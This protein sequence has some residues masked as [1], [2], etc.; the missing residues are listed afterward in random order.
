MCD[1]YLTFRPYARFPPPQV[2]IHLILYRIDSVQLYTL[3]WAASV[4]ALFFVTVPVLL[5]PLRPAHI[6]LY[7]YT[8]NSA[9]GF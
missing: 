4:R 1:R 2:V 8:R 6:F 7:I 9:N 3:K 5:G